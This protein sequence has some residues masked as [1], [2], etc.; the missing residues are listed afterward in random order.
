[1][2]QT[3]TFLLCFFHFLA[4]SQITAGPDPAPGNDCFS[5]P[6]TLY[7]AGDVNGRSSYSYFD[8]QFTYTM[9]WNGAMWRFEF[10]GAFLLSSNDANTLEPPCSSVFPWTVGLGCDFATAPFIGGPSCSSVPLSIELVSFKALIKNHLTILEWV[11]ARELGNAGFEVERSQGNDLHWEKIGFV[12]GSG[13]KASPSVYTFTDDQ[14]T[15]GQIYYRLIWKGFDGTSGYSTSLPVF[16]EPENLVSLTPNPVKDALTITLSETSESTSLLRLYD[17]QG[18]LLQTCPLL[19]PNTNIDMT[20][21]P[22]GFYWA[23]IIT[24]GRRNDRYLLLKN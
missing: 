22:S 11:T 17:A 12:A 3:F 9:Y 15:E 14:R 5:S 24:D 6:I 21:C 16:K 2:R 4:Q 23:E 13:E 19:E 18:R 1:M 10:E 8:G 7:Y 20:I